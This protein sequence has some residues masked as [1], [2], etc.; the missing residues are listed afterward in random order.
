MVRDDGLWLM[1]ANV[2]AV[3]V[4]AEWM[5]P[6]NPGVVG[7]AIGGDRTPLDQVASIGAEGGGRLSP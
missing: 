7:A 4:G 1:V 3:M 5:M 2:A 6:C